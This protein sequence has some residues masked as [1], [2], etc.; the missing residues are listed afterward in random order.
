MSRVK[1]AR[2]TILVTDAGRGSA[3]SIIRSLGRKG[4]HVI[5]ADADPRSPG[6]RSR[7]AAERLCYPAP[8]T[9][10]RELVAT[11]L[12]TARERQVDLIIP[13]TDAIILPLAGARDEFAD[14]CA[15]AMPDPAALDVVTNKLKTLELAERL[16]VP[17]PRTALVQST[18]EAAER[19]P[20]LGWPIVLKPQNS[21]LYREQAVVEA[22]TVCYAENP[23]RLAEQMARFEGRCPVLLQEYYCGSG[24]GVELLMHEGRPLAAFQHKRLRE[25]PVN[26]GASAFRESVPLDTE[27]Y[28]HSVRLLEALNWTGLAMVEFKVGAEGPKLMEINGRVWGSLPLAVRSGMDFPARLAELYLY[29]PPV[30]PA[31]ESRYR[32]GVR[33][34]NLEL[35][36][37]WIAS[38]LRGKRRYP[39]LAMPSRR[40]G[41]AALLGLLNPA[42]KFDI[43]SLDDPRPGLA[44]IIKIVGKFGGKL[45]EA[46]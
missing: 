12:Q 32:V 37:V 8:E 46:T 18:R 34:R 27:L 20:A 17:T 41:M 13:V 40:E 36:M 35:D 29:G 22:F 26:G 28:R 44:E 42:Y 7:Y 25:V 24:Q 19:G 45:K 30:E 21:R 1:G 16:G 4:W 33:A 15:L 43:L 38:V 11:L 10:P 14:V 31:T 39:F 9:A 2:P 5:A 6:F 3:I 23:E